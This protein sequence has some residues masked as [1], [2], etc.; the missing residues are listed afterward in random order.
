MA[1]KNIGGTLNIGFKALKDNG[2]FQKL[3]FVPIPNAPVVIS[4][5][6]VRSPGPGVGGELRLYVDG[7]LGAEKLGINNGDHQLLM[8]GLG[9]LG[10]FR[11]GTIGE[12][13]FDD[14]LSGSTP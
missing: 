9:N 4:G 2:N 10:L 3:P 13:R 6:W 11:P 14:F 1:V 12:I 7:V 5:E 8:P